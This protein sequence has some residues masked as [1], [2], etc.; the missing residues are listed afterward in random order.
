MATTTKYIPTQTP[1]ATPTDLHAEE[2]GA[3]AEAVKQPIRDGTA[4]RE[5]LATPAAREVG[6]L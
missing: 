6:N 4:G 2:V 3:I 1:L 5:S